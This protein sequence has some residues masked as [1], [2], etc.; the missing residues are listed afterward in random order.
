LFV[1][2]DSLW[3]F[4]YREIREFGYRSL[5]WLAGT[6]FNLQHILVTIHGPGYGLDEM[7]AFESEIAGFVEAITAGN[8]PKSLARITVVEHH[9]GRAQRLNKLLT[10]LLPER[11]I[12]IPGVSEPQ[13][14]GKTVTTRLRRVGYD[15]ADKPYVLV[16]MP[17][18][19][20]MEDVFHYG[21]QGVVNAAGL[22]CER[23]DLS[24]FTGGDAITR[25]KS[26]VSRSSLVI[27]DISTADPKRL[28]EK[29]RLP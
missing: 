6:S 17:F 27:A 13:T 19:E 5:A 29:F 2:V 4:G 24:T 12:P 18:S 9:R 21:I 8:Y 28:F 15:S 22:L 11:G 26:R 7:E 25:V 16:I 10:H 23:A 1:G 3:Q 14:H 20:E